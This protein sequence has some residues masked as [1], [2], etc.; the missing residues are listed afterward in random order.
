[1]KK[2]KK[3]LAL[4]LAVLLLPAT[5]FM[6]GCAGRTTLYNETVATFDRNHNYVGMTLNVFN[7]GMFMADGTYGSLN[8]VR[9]FEQLTGIR[10][11]FRTYDSNEEMHGFIRS[12]TVPHDLVIPSEYMVQ[13]MI[14]ENLLRPLD[15]SL[16]SNLNLVDTA[17]MNQAFDPGNRYSI[18]YKYGF[19]G[20]IYNS[21]EFARNNIPSP[22]GWDVLFDYETFG[23]N[24]VGRGR[25]RTIN[26]R[27]D[28][29]AIAQAYL[30]LDV[31]SLNPA[32]WE[33][34]AEL[35]EHQF[36][37]VTPVMDGIFEDLGDGSAWVGA[38]YAGDFLTM[39]ES[40]P[41]LRIVF[42][43]QGTNM[44]IN[45]MAIPVTSQN[46]GAAHMFINF[47]L[48]PEVAMENAEWIRYASPNTTVWADPN[49]SLRNEPALAHRRRDVDFIF[50]D[51][52]SMT[53]TYERLWSNLIA[54]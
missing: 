31:N 22:T 10:V 29:F 16:I 13:R 50:E 47:L 44:F 28:A 40:N 34:A 12:G 49:F 9:A 37:F 33:A 8:I 43:E 41:D 24:G 20:L 32:D 26:N 42:P 36:T 45:S 35:L 48:E 23:P 15:H 17:F 39:R 1:M 7:W 6:S 14:R 51:I 53:T 3:I 11:N 52:P 4:T 5:L 54:G 25:A 21:A 27:R 2:I 38:Y 46:P 19:V 18:P 30:G